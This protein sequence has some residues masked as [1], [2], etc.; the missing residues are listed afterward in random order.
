MTIGRH[1]RVTAKP[2]VIGQER[3]QPFLP[4]HVVGQDSH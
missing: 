2:F 4:G 3:I 1:R